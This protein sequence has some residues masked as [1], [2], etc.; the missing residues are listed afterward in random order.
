[1]RT[2]DQGLLLFTCAWKHESR[3]DD[4]QN[5][6]AQPVWVAIILSQSLNE[7]RD[8]DAILVAE[9]DLA[10]AAADMNGSDRRLCNEHLCKW[11]IGAI[12]C[13]DI[14]VRVELNGLSPVADPLRLN[15]KSPF[16][17]ESVEAR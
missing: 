6:L 7:I 3:D 15:A 14:I 5:V 9:L 2:N 13:E 17:Q 10:R 11:G 16:E 4:R 8:P 1:M 12:C